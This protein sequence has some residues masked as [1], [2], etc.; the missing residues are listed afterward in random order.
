MQGVEE[1]MKE[2]RTV[3]H[4]FV[5]LCH[6][7]GINLMPKCLI[8]WWEEKRKTREMLKGGESNKDSNI[9]SHMESHGRW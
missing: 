7:L 6:P 3:S 1:Q 5:G 4:I 8:T 2:S 9:A